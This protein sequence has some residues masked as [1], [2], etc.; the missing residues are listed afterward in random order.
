MKKITYKLSEDTFDKKEIN[1]V[2]KLFKSKQKL[3]Y[4]KNVKLLE[5]KIAK[6]HNR[7]Y[8]IMVNSGSSA[9]LLG[10]SAV[11][12][13]QKFNLKIDLGIFFSD[14]VSPILSTAGFEK[15]RF[16]NVFFRTSECRNP[17]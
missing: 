5:K 17:F 13:D 7:K 3:S 11:L 9:N 15:G 8:A 16:S 6:I 4:G 14:S 12:F 10:V 1:T 2:V